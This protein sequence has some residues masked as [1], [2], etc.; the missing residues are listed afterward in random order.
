MDNRNG[1]FAGSDKNAGVSFRVAYFINSVDRGRMPHSR[2][3]F[4][5]V[6]QVC[7]FEI[8]REIRFVV[9]GFAGIVLQV[10]SQPTESPIVHGEDIRIA[11]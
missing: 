6:Y 5:L 2:I 8:Q 9:C 10:A 1:S 3:A 4:L 7:D 11:R